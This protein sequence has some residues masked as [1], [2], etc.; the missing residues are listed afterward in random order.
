LGRRNKKIGQ[1]EPGTGRG[2]RALPGP[3]ENEKQ[4]RPFST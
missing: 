4:E 3:T 1:S 2:G